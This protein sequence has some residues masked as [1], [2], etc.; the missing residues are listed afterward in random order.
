MNIAEA[1]V[2]VVGMLKGVLVV[3]GIAWV[4]V[5]FLRHRH[6]T[7]APDPMLEGEL[8]ALRDQ[9][10]RMQQQ[11]TEAHERLDFTERLLSRFRAPEVSPRGAS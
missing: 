5:Q 10:D 8:A 9:M 6:S 11:L 4:A 3:W 2:Q 1:L 7:S